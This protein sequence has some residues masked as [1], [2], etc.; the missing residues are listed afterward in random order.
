MN[1]NQIRKNYERTLQL[2]KDIIAAD[3]RRRGFETQR[4]WHILEM[5]QTVCGHES[6]VRLIQNQP[7]DPVIFEIAIRQAGDEV[8]RELFPDIFKHRFVSLD[9][10][11]VFAA[12]K[13]VPAEKDWTSQP[14]E[15]QQ[16]ALL[17]QLQEKLDS[18]DHQFFVKHIL[19]KW[20][21]Q[22]YFL[23]ALY[24]IAKRSK[25]N[26]IG[27]RLKL[28]RQFYPDGKIPDTSQINGLMDLSDEQI[29]SCYKN[30]YSGVERYFPANFLQHEG[31]HRARLLTRFL[32]NEI[33]QTTPEKVLRQKDEIFFI[34]HRLQ[35]I[36]R[37]FNYS[38]NRV[39]RCA[40]PDHIQPWLNSRTGETYW[41]NAA[42]RQLA[43]RWLVEQK[44]GLSSDH[45]F[46]NKISRK[47]FTANG[48]SYLY[49]RYYNSVSRALKEAYPDKRPWELGNVPLS[50]WTDETAAIAVRWLVEKNGWRAEQLPALAKQK[51][52]T[53]KTFSS[54]GLASLI[55]MKFKKN[56]YQ[57]VNLAYPHCF[58]PWEFGHVPRAFWDEQN[59]V[60]NAAL[61]IAQKQ[62]I[63][64]TEI[65]GSVRTG[66]LSFFQFAEYSI[67][68]VLKRLS[69]GS[70]ENL[71]A[72]QFRK[73]RRQY[74]EEYRLL[75]KLKAMIRKEE[76]IN[77]L[78]RFL[79]YG[80]F[81][82]FIQTHSSEHVFRLQRM[83]RRMERRR[84][85]DYAQSGSR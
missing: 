24:R 13:E 21:E 20:S 19:L 72:P 52:F 63:P 22:S 4:Q 23:S 80:I 82:P 11:T 70:M 3:Q 32:I 62:G 42:H 79:L 65:V 56:L 37:Y 71:F 59:N 25:F 51:Q 73:E 30:V 34:H 6:V 33:L 43:V 45:L 69:G 68:A 47:D 54:F 5:A 81:A 2:A 28:I 85:F 17:R 12:L 50:Y 78:F 15:A 76:E 77:P 83:K 14:N 41:Q 49:N 38:T 55:E 39:L 64:H 8:G 61:W 48:L 16:T 46:K 74:L 1:I 57:A 60:Q 58:Q 44:A 29:I 40:Y 75:N 66:K 36:Y 31:E 27:Q 26:E 35:N 10:P 67:G 18:G 84:Q 9:D 7:F 53:A